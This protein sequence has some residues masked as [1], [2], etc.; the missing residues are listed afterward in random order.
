[1]LT[2]IGYF[3]ICRIVERFLGF[4]DVSQGR[5]AEELFNFLTESFQKFDL[6]NK[7]VA[8]TYD[9]A[10]VMAGQLNGLQSK[11]KS[12]AP[13]ALLIHCYAHVLNLVLSKSCNS[14]KRTKILDL[15]CGNR[16]P[17]SA[18]TRWNFT[19]RAVFTTHANKNKLICR[20]I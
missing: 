13:Q 14:I 20:C 6:K 12:V 4:Y 2:V 18:P 19:S 17:T 9:G 7:L 3:S 5:T 15:I 16:L 8:Q 10:A 11:I 1:L